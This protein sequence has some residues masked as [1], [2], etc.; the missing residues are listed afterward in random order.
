M[1]WATD[2][3]LPTPSFIIYF[4]EGTRYSGFAINEPKGMTLMT[5]LTAAKAARVLRNLGFTST[6]NYKLLDRERHLDTWVVGRSSLGMFINA[7]SDPSVP[8]GLEA[9]AA[10]CAKAEEV[11]RALFDA[12]YVV[13][14]QVD[15]T[16]NPNCVIRSSGS[17]VIV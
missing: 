12:G 8:R 5:D 17:V 10:S 9:I 2:K 14:S 1:A 3:S 6:S 11:A 13:A 7:A 15:L 4:R 16:R